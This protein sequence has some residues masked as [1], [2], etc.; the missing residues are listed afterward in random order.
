MN[1]SI[2]IILSCVL[3]ASVLASGKAVKLKGIKIQADNEAP[4]V[5]HII[6]WQTP[7]GAERLYTPIRGVDIERLAPLDPYSFELEQQLHQQWVDNNQLQA[8][9]VGKI[10]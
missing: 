10:R 2:L 3:S 6:P 1:K 5:M 7:V 4:Q 8:D 9:S